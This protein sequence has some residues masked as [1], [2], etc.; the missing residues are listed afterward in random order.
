M[1][2]KVQAFQIES[3]EDISKALDE[4]FE[5]TIAFTSKSRDMSHQMEVVNESSE[6]PTTSSIEVDDFISIEDYLKR[7]V[8]TEEQTQPT[9]TYSDKIFQSEFSPNI[10]HVEFESSIGW[11]AENPTTAVASYCKKKRR[12]CN[13]IAYI[14]E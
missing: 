6:I 5:K 13:R 14:S 11:F 3:K 12:I 10:S 2:A 4:L 8:T 1:I 9:N 7:K